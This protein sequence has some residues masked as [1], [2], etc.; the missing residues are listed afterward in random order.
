[1]VG[2]TPFRGAAAIEYG[3]CGLRKSV[4]HQAGRQVALRCGSCGEA[5]FARP[6]RLGH[7]TVVELERAL[8]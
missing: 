8:T 6:S 7:H 1:V 3:G 2:R 4:F 5:I